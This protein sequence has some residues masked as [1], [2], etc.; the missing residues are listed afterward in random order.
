ML[1]QHSPRLDSVAKIY[2]RAATWEDVSD[3]V[4]LRCGENLVW[5][6]VE[7]LPHRWVENTEQEMVLHNRNHSDDEDEDD[8]IGN[9]TGSRQ[10]NGGSILKRNESV[11]P[12][13]YGEDDDNPCE[14][15]NSR[16]LEGFPMRSRKEL[17]TELVSHIS[18]I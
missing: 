15:N 12:D 7:T 10:D 16:A 17:A 14:D 1:T 4:S 8:G 6:A 5:W 18:G 11:Q 9:S 13:H 3:M 2:S